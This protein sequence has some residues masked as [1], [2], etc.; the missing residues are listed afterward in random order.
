[1]D[2]DRP[3]Q[4]SPFQETTWEVMRNAGAD[5]KRGTDDPLWMSQEGLGIAPPI[6]TTLEARMRCAKANVQ[7]GF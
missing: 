6:S 1:M 7:V 2:P 4:A 5:G 3:S